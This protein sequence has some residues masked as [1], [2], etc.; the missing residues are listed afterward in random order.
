ML[1]A[2]T[3]AMACLCMLGTCSNNPATQRLF[4]LFQ[5]Y[6]TIDQNMKQASLL[7]L[8]ILRLMIATTNRRWDW[9]ADEYCQAQAFCSQFVLICIWT[10]L[11]I[12]WLHSSFN[13][14][15]PKSLGYIC[16]F[17]RLA[18]QQWWSSRKQTHTK[19]LTLTAGSDLPYGRWPWD[20]FGYAVAKLTFTAAEKVRFPAVT[21]FRHTSTRRV[22]KV[23]Q[24]PR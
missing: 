4:A 10:N 19:D 9:L 17:Y 7:C 14:N 11:S 12:S 15:N 16:L 6:L 8:S 5:R 21:F 18:I 13:E 24:C 2:L 22:T 1:S 23:L 20:V 3:V